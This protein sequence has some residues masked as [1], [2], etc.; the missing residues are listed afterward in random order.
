M[1]KIPYS[2][3]M[4][5]PRY[6]RDHGWFQCDNTFKFVS[7]GF[8]RCSNEKREIMFD[9]RNIILFPFQFIF[10][11]LICSTETNMSEREVRTQ[12]KRMED[13]GFLKKAT[14]KTPNRFTIYEW[15]L[16][17]FIKSKDQVKDQQSTKYRPS[18]DHNQDNKIIRSIDNTTPTPLPVVAVFSCLEKINDPSVKQADKVSITRKYHD[19]EQ[20]VIDAVAIVTASDFVP[21]ETILKALWGMCK[22]QAKPKEPKENV[23]QKNR[24]YAKKAKEKYKGPYGFE[25]L[26]SGFEI[27][28]GVNAA[29]EI[30]KWD[31]SHENFKNKVNKILKL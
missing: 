2:F 18:T 20:I 12:A 11:R 8:S 3:E 23:V 24:E 9:G 27:M 7:W 4:P 5:P 15:V 29:S 21:E 26:N 22:I 19:K 14:N 13:S 16:D 17:G 10:G 30:I 1:S 28:K 6:F 31:E 25:K